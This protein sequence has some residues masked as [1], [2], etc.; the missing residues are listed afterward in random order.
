[1]GRIQFVGVTLL[2]CSLS[3]PAFSQEEKPRLV[4]NTFENPSNYGQSTIGNAL[5]DILVTE[6][7]KGGSVRIIDPSLYSGQAGDVDYFLSAKVTNFS[8]QEKQIE[9]QGSSGRAG[10]AAS[11]KLYQQTMEVRIDF[12]VS[13]ATSGEVLLADT[14]EARE[15]N[16]SVEAKVVDFNRLVAARAAIS[17]YEFRGSIMGRASLTAVQDAVRKITS[18]LS[19][20]RTPE[21]AEIS[22]EI[23]GV[24]DANNLFVSL[25]TNDGLK[26]RD[27]LNIYR[28]V[29]IENSKG[30]TIYTDRERIGSLEIVESQPD[31][32]KAK[33]V[34]GS[35]IK[36]GDVAIREAPEVS[37][38]DHI[39][40]GSA[41]LERQFY[42]QA[43]EEFKEAER[44]SPDSP[45]VLKLIGFTYLSMNNYK[46]ALPNLQKVID[47]GETLEFWIRHSHF[48]GGCRGYLNVSKNSL[49]FVSKHGFR[50]DSAQLK[51]VE[52]KQDSATTYLRVSTPDKN[53]N[54]QYFIIQD[55]EATLVKSET[56][57]LYEEPAAAVNS[58]VLRFI[59]AQLK[60]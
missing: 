23:L 52:L 15:T 51:Q 2:I 42:A 53:F 7:S 18:Y 50:I 34:S 17:I 54:F 59:A 1:M 30:E 40:N 3:R 35:E 11:G 33:L 48:M 39:K 31:R 9:G 29:P 47:A 14:G 6:L 16:Q 57:L 12:R 41:L 58:G 46:E 8:Y 5:T 19:I 37:V 45:T 55:E 10:Q 24:I 43:L 20:V 21:V 32:S 25:G 22:G 27:V 26:V 28:E 56:L 4:V 44:K 38:D 13:N 49:E 36:E 60:R